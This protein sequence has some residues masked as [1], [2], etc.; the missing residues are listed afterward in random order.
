MNE[1]DSARDF[2]AALDALLDGTPQAQANGPLATAGR[3][4]KADFSAETRLRAPLRAR[5]LE[6]VPN[7]RRTLYP[8]LAWAGAFVVIAVL[9]PLLP[10]RR[11]ATQ[12]HAFPRGELGL[13]V[14][15]GYLPVPKRAEA[16]TVFTTVAA[17]TVSTRNGTSIVWQFEAGALVLERRRITMRDIFV[18]PKL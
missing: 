12:R 14:L 11:P 13:P 4:A 16:Q 10:L 15:P 2:C 1:E 17:K 9:L 18:T 3:L 7:P 8:R 6:R 5:L